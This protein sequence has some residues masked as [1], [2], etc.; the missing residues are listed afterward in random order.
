[1]K[2]STFWEPTEPECLR[3][4]C[5]WNNCCPGLT[6]L[7]VGSGE[8]FFQTFCHEAEKQPEKSSR[9]TYQEAQGKA[10]PG[11]A[12]TRVMPGLEGKSRAFSPSC[13][14]LVWPMTF[15]C[16]NS[17]PY[18]IWNPH[19]HSTPSTFS[20]IRA[21]TSSDWWQ[22]VIVHCCPMWGSSSSM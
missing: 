13:S 20:S 19:R 4:L 3:G 11:T 10:Q 7:W 2:G 14:Y 12:K 16:L 17:H 18:A 9:K 15:Q 5:H 21:L 1:M 6:N 8:G 22:R